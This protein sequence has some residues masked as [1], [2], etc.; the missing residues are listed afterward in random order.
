VGVRRVVAKAL[1]DLHG[2][3][4]TRVGADRLIFPE[5]DT[6]L[7]LAHSWSSADITD[8]LD[9]V[10]G[11]MVSR[12]QAPAELVG[13]SIGDAIGREQGVTLMLLARGTRV[14]IYPPSQEE[15]REG[16]VL[17]LAGQLDELDRFFSSLE[18]P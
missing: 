5:R 13:K 14:T 7:R 8:S 2:E 3:I 12:V 10:E 18:S 17:V 9:I 15:L 1:N 16:D 4:L 6:G 11:F